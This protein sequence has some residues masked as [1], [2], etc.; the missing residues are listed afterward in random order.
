MKTRTT[1][2]Y[3]NGCVTL[4]KVLETIEYCQCGQA[5]TFVKKDGCYKHT[6]W[7]RRAGVESYEDFL[8]RTNH[9]VVIADK[10]TWVT[11]IPIKKES[12]N[13]NV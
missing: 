8:S 11:W 7:K 12:N 3:D 5:V 1:E 9:P 4:Q 13:A 2:F 6:G 10:K